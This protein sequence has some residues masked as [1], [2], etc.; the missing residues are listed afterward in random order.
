MGKCGTIIMCDINVPLIAGRKRT[1]Y[2]LMFQL[3][4]SKIS[5]FPRRG[6]GNNEEQEKNL[7]A[8]Q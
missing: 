8:E 5:L 2:I 7:I 1:F 4:V 3:N 6:Q